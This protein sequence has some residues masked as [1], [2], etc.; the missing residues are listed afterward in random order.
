MPPNRVAHPEAASVRR[1][2]MWH[3]HLVPMVLWG[4]CVLSPV[5]ASAYGAEP[6]DDAYTIATIRRFVQDVAIDAEGY[7]KAIDFGS[8]TLTANVL[9]VLPNLR[10]VESLRFAGTQVGDIELARLARLRTLTNLDLSKAKADLRSW[11]GLEALVTLETLRVPSTFT[12]AHLATLP[13]LP[14]L[15]SLT[16]AGS[17]VSDA[18]LVGLTNV[19]SVRYLDLS[20]TR[21]GDAATHPLRSL[22]N[23]ET[24]DL[25]GTNLSDTGA[26]GLARLKG[27]R[28]LYL[29]CTNVTDAGVRHIASLSN[30]RLLSAPE[31]VG[32]RGVE[33]LT[34]LLTWLQPPDRVR[35]RSLG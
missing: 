22:P 35:L 19:T 24:L 31:R 29:K 34:R 13:R 6:G 15:K 23:L 28:F 4:I 18:G 17:M 33:Y 21:V 30:L 3:R 8:G 20:N 14:G 32:D 25:S 2:A 26:E 5:Q 12:D 16:L 10:K 1:C 11:A 27:L 7:V 9:M